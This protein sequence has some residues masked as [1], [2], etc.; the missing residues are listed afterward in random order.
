[1]L[2]GR[3]KLFA[4]S[5]T[6][7]EVGAL[8]FVGGAHGALRGWVPGRNCRRASAEIERMCSPHCSTPDGFTA[9]RLERLVLPACQSQHHSLFKMVLHSGVCITQLCTFQL[10]VRGNETQFAPIHSRGHAM[11]GREVHHVNGQVNYFITDHRE[12]CKAGQTRE[13]LTHSHDR[14][15]VD[16]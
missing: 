13:I 1:M 4:R 7:A 11:H 3:G 14:R 9:E 2:A 8:S 12:D 6:T 5:R 10:R 16:H 15:H